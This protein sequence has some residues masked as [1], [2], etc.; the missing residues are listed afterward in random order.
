MSL[1]EATG[2]VRVSAHVPAV[3]SAK[4]NVLVR[5]GNRQ[6]ATALSGKA[7]RYSSIA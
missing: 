7:L 1:R 5:L 6:D 2:G 3:V 4:Q